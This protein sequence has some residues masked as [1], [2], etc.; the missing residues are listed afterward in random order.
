M[1]SIFQLSL[2]EKHRHKLVSLKQLVHKRIQNTNFRSPYITLK[3]YAVFGVKVSH[4][5]FILSFRCVQSMQKFPDSLYKKM[6]GSCY[7]TTLEIK[8]SQF[9]FK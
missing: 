9:N 2:P 3:F 6:T 7:G 1:L 8:R 4:V 5:N